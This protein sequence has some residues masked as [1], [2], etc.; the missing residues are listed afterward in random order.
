MELAGLLVGFQGLLFVITG[1]EAGLL[2]AISGNAAGSGPVLLSLGL[3][4][5]SLSIGSRLRLGR[6]RKTARVLQW[7]LIVWAA[8]DLLLALLM[9]QALLP[10]VA[11]FT[12]TAMPIAVLLLTRRD[13]S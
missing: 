13:R 2:A 4:V 8:L 10:P 3:A 12:R 6:W 9:A 11:M 7:L 1:I 5:A